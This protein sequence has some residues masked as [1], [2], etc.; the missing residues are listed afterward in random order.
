MHPESLDDH[1]YELHGI[2]DNLI[3]RLHSLAVAEE[4]YSVACF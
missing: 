1:N 2:A 4:H 3:Q